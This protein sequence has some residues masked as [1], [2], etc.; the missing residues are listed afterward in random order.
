MSGIAT[1]FRKELTDHLGSRRFAIIAAIIVLASLSAVLSA[2]ES[3]VLPQ[4][5]KSALFLSL[6]TESGGNLPSFLFFVTFLM[7]LLGI[8]LGF[9][10]INAERQRGTLSLL[11]SQPIYRDSLI[12]G[13]F[14]AA[15]GT[16]AL[17]KAGILALIGGIAISRLGIIP[18]GTEILRAAV[19]FGASMFYAAFWLS[20]AILFSVL[21]DKTSTSALAAIALWIFLVF[22]VQLVAGVVADHVAPVGPNAVAEEILRH[23]R[24]RIG[25]MRFSP[26]FL[27]QEISLVVLNPVVRILGPL[28]ADQLREIIPSPLDISQSLMVIWPQLTV[29]AALSILCFGISYVAFMRREIRS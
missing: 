26:A 3:P 21:F 2:V 5:E 16:M 29:L 13:K 12:N 28:P 18:N 8:L 23:E 24:L 4:R 6:L 1:I 9:D 10:A 15:L 25:L 17:M 7:P 19:F 22:F 11:I 20:L 27:L 14:L